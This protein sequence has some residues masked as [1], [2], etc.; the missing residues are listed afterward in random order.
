MQEIQIKIF[1]IVFIQCNSDRIKNGKR[2]IIK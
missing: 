1:V 2:E